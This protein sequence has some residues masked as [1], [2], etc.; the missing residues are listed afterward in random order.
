MVGSRISSAITILALMG[1][2]T[3]ALAAESA[4]GMASNRMA[5][6]MPIAPEGATPCPSNAAGDAAPCDPVTGRGFSWPS[7]RFLLAGIASA[8]AVAA[9]AAGTSG[10]GHHSAGGGTSPV[11]P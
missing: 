11:S 7:I 8:G 4:S 5:L 9:V 3:P 10:G 1:W 2:S 6:A